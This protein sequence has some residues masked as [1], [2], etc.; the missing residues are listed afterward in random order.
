MRDIRGQN[1]IEFVILT[2]LVVVGLVMSYAFLGD[3]I[4]EMLGHSNDSVEGFEPFGEGT[5]A[6]PDS[7]A[8]TGLDSDDPAG[9]GG[10]DE[11]IGGG[12]TLPSSGGL[13]IAYDADGSAAFTVGSQ[14]VTLSSDIVDDIGIVFE[15]SGADGIQDYVADAI[16]ALIQEYADE[17]PDNN[18]PVEVNFGSSNRQVNYHVDHNQDNLTT[19]ANQSPLIIP[20]KESIQFNGTAQFNQV[21]IQVGDHYI[22]LVNDQG[23]SNDIASSE[24]G[25]YQIEGDLVNGSF[26][27]TIDALKIGDTDQQNNNSLINDCTVTS[28]RN[29]DGSG[30]VFQLNIINHNINDVGNW[31]LNLTGTSEG[32]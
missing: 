18:V 22:I 20:N 1:L 14:N 19:L 11:P 4:N 30:G 17:Y 5:Y 24:Q 16:A 25:V 21:S 9:G 12:D 26:T 6:N 8:K 32:V 13:D 2:S 27:G 15:T 10:A 23:L 31:D 29:D 7:P 3:N 28:R